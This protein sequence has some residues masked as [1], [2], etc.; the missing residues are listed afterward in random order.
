MYWKARTVSV[1]N[2][3]MYWNSHLFPIE[4]VVYSVSLPSCRTSDAL[5][6]V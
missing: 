2:A 5:L 6:P 1:R 3:T 4:T